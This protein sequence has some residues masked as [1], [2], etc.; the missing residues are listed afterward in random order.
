M[1]R[2][3]AFAACAIAAAFA[4][5]AAADDVC[6]DAVTDP[7]ATPLRDAR[8]DAQRG[9]CLR[10]EVAAA[11]GAHALIDTPGFH[12][13]LGGDVTLR[14][15]FRLGERVEV[16]ALARVVDYAFAQTAVNKATALRF[17]PLVLEAAVAAVRSPR[18]QLAVVAALE[19]PA[20]R[21]DTDTTRTGGQLA[22]VFTGELARRWTL[23][24]RIGATGAA[25]SSAGGETRRLGLRGGAD[26]VWRGGRRALLVGAELQ[27]GWHD[28]FDT[29]LVRAGYVQRLGAAWRGVVGL[30]VP[31][32]GNDRTNAAVDLGVV[33]TL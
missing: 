3:A 30:G 29:T 16:G 13:F 25:A 28:G 10:S 27:A 20:T 1:I 5:V 2:G 7:V 32:G 22:A 15:R 19:V 33:R 6:A 17:G 9:A 8:I 26:A 23:H 11:I 24:A 12:G 21:D 31:I 4:R 14:G 18:A